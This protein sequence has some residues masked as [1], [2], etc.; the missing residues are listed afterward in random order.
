[1]EKKLIALALAALPCAS[2]ADVT[3]YGSLQSGFENVRD[4]GT[5]SV[6]RVADLGSRIGFKGNEDLGN[7]LKAIWQVESGFRLDGQADTG[8]SSGT[9]GS[10]NTFVGVEGGFGKLRV[11]NIT[12]TLDTDMEIF[13]LFS[14]EA[15]ALKSNMTK[16]VHSG[17]DTRLKNSIRYDAPL[18]GGFALSL[19]HGV[20]E[21]KNLAGHGD[22]YVD[23]VG[24]GY[25]AGALAVKYGAARS[26]DQNATKSAGLY[27]RAEAAYNFGDL[28][29]AGGFASDK[30]Y[31]A[32]GAKFRQNEGALTVA[33]SVGAF[34]PKFTYTKGWDVR[35]NG[36]RL[37]D[38]GY[39]HYL[40]GVGY[41]VSKRTSLGLSYG[42]LDY[43]AKAVWLD[44]SGNAA[45]L[46]GQRA[47]GLQ[48][49]H[50]F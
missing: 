37:A 33:Y 3:V 40:V 28:L 15:N 45:P 21:S 1:M 19:H 4:D 39:K 36:N 48:I 27:Q 5:P 23:I 30:A 6:N 38:S 10:R 31:A 34:T 47:S 44:G 12:T 50:N 20:D 17:F 7:G 11:G 24:A 18:G 41:A 35:Q 43:D 9:F 13:D 32:S 16:G 8:S 25:S 22:R 49:V 29:L 14:S 42:K 26:N 46:K 2:M